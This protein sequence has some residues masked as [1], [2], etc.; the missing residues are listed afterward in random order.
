MLVQPGIEPEHPAQQTGALPTRLTR[1]FFDGQE[2]L[3]Y[4]N[5]MEIKFKLKIHKNVQTINYNNK[6][7]NGAPLQIERLKCE[8]VTKAL[9]DLDDRVPNLV[10]LLGWG[11]VAPSLTSIYSNCIVFI[12]FLKR[13]ENGTV[14]SNEQ[15]R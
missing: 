4:D 1:L 6:V 15:E 5:S 12:I 9:K 10:L 13:K 7:V 11:E 2:T 8:K 14:E 3:N